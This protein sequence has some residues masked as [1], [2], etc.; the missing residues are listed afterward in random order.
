MPCG[1]DVHFKL[2]APHNT[3]VEVILRGGKIEL[4]RVMPQERMK[5]VKI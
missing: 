2:H 5:D 3:T 1:W 4:L